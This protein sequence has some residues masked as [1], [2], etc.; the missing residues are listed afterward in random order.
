[1]KSNGSAPNF[2]RQMPTLEEIARLAK[3]SRSTVSRVVNN[4][5]NV[6]EKTRL[7]VQDV[8]RNLDFQPN[9]AARTLAGGRSH[10]LGLVIPM[11]VLRLFS[12]PYFPLLIHGV[13]SAC[14]TFEYSLMLWMVEPEYERR[15]INQVLHNGMTDGIIVASS[16]I[17]DP[18]ILS[19]AQSSLPFLVVGRHPVNPNVSYIDMDNTGASRQIVNY[20]LHKGCRRIATITGPQNMI[21]GIDRLE[22]YHQAFKDWGLTPD[23]KL[24]VDGGFSEDGAFQAM[25]QLL[26]DSNSPLIEAVYAASDMMAIGAIRA[27]Q[28]AGLCVPQD[29]AVVGF[30]DIPQAARHEPP[31]TTVRQFIQRTGTVA[32]ETLIRMIERP[33]LPP[34]RI[35]LPTE[36]VIRKSG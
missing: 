8:I 34:Q 11:G 19:L 32:V 35:I 22:G 27:I 28:E 2:L 5:P 16:L 30:D 1:M 14:N 29:I 24:I 21:A 3:V 36:L 7:R 9:R 18:I 17:D 25:R 10:V 26:T 6:S 20:L 13:N 15:M 31:L 33:D 12:D 23:P 4:D